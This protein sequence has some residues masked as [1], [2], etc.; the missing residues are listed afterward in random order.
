MATAATVSIQLASESAKLRAD[1]DKLQRDVKRIDGASKALKKSMTGVGKA[2]VGAFSIGAVTAFT[3]AIIRATAQQEKAFAQLQAAVQSTGGVAG[4]TAEELAG[5]ASGLQQVTT[6]GDE[7]VIAMQSVLLTFT[8]VRGP[9]FKDAQQAII[10]VS[11]RLGKDLTSSALQVGKA[12]NDPIKGVSALA[13]AGI[14]FTAAQKEQIKALVEGGRVA[15]A[16]RIILKELEIQFGGSAAAARNTLGGALASVKN[17]FGDLLEQKDGAPALTGA[18]NELSALLSDPGTKQAADTL[19]TGLVSAAASSVKFVTE[20]TGGLQV[21]TGTTGNTIEN[22]GRDIEAI[23]E[24]VNRLQGFGSLWGLTLTEE[25]KRQISAWEAQI[26]AY[27]DLQLRLIEGGVGAVRDVFSPPT[28]TEDPVT[29]TPDVVN[30]AARAR[31]ESSAGASILDGDTFGYWRTA[32][33]GAQEA[34]DQE[35][36]IATD[37]VLQLQALE[38]QMIDFRVSAAD[39]ITEA[40]FGASQAQI[41]I[42]QAK[43]QTFASLA[44]QA[45][46]AGLLAGGRVAKW[47]KAYA[48]A[49]VV[50]STSRGIMKAWAEVPWP[51]NILQAAKIA[52]AGAIQLAKIKSTNPGISGTIAAGGYGSAAGEVPAV[53]QTTGESQVQPRSQ[54]QIIVQGHIFSSRES[55]Q[56]FIDQVRDAIN[57]SDVTII[58]RNSRQALELAEVPA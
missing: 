11:T 32:V 39:R 42:E 14:Q 23:Q 19:L 5:M 12:L 20:L 33:E 27:S 46:Q 47:A 35:I 57:D 41:A 4:F 44:Q 58:G 24:K 2:I 7:A 55:A 34:A 48:I 50:W 36:Q 21:L 13:E 40:V 49:D 37:R 15:D 22:L 9:V 51:A 18:L 10:D 52:A 1:L 17:A 53:Q 16:Q 38:Q 54:A 3:G 29:P 28:A 43:T 31:A 30:A 8:Q 26:Q 56:W 25:N 6:F 45:A